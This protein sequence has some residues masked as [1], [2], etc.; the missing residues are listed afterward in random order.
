M[1]N[2]IAPIASVLNVTHKDCFD[3]LVSAWVVRKW[4]ADN[5][6]AYT[7]M[8]GDY[9]APLPD[10]SLFLDKVVVIT[11]FSYPISFVKEIAIV[12]RSIY[13][14][15]HHEAA[16]INFE[17][18]MVDTL[19]CPVSACF[20]P[21]RSGAGIAWN[22]LY[23][24]FDV[25]LIV[26]AAQDHDLWKFE[27]D[28]T[29]PVMAYLGMLGLSLESVSYVHDNFALAVDK[30]QLLV[31]KDDKM[32]EWHLNNVYYLDLSFFNAP[33]VAIV[34]APRYIASKV[35][36]R[37]TDKYPL[38]I[39]Y[40]DYADYRKG[41]LRSNGKWN[42][43]CSEIA[44]LYNG[45]GNPKTAGCRFAKDVSVD[46]YLLTNPRFIPLISKAAKQETTA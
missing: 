3:G 9:Q 34:N 43:N 40:E 44:Q 18:L 6:Y 36:D 33:S 24:Y 21:T 32:V 7:T 46:Q 14:Y 29:K 19:G 13:I 1:P 31:D 12:A 15:D 17:G 2:A 45:A 23:P 4:A 16:A 30:G 10:I 27:Y 8:Y 41:S 5:G 35:A 28:F 38:V 25:P 11:D 22:Q 20:D 39:M 37:L 42:I 26:K